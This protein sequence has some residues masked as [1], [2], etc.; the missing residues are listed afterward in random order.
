MRAKARNVVERAE[1]FWMAKCVLA[2]PAKKRPQTIADIPVVVNSALAL[3]LF[4]KT[5]LTL[6]EI[7]FPL[8][9]NLEFLFGLL[10]EKRQRRLLR[11]HKKYEKHPHFARLISGGTKTDLLTLL[12]IGKHCFNKFRY[13]HNDPS[14]KDIWALDVCLILTR[15]MAFRAFRIE[16]HAEFTKQYQ[17]TLDR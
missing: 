13:T 6:D 12:N 9:H 16:P 4:F 14:Q 15:D 7:E 11:Q 2:V 3:E 5:L 8:T 1:A 10:S 17:S